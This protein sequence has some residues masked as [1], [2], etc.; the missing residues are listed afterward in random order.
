MKT[1][2]LKSRFL[3]LIVFFLS[4]VVISQ[5]TEVMIRAKSKDAKF[6]GTSLGGARIIVKDE[7]TGKILAQGMT[8]GSTG[9]TD[10][11]MNNPQLRGKRISDENTAGF[12]AKLDIKEPVFVTIEAYGPV[13]KKQ[14][15]VKTTTQ[16][17]IL[18]G[19]H[20]KGEGIILEIPGFVVDILSPQTHESIE[21]NTNIEITANVVMMC[22]CPVTE[23]GVWD[24]SKYEVKAL[25]SQDGTEAINTDLKVMG[26]P[27]TFQGSINLK[28]G[29]YEI[30]VYAFDPETGNTGVDKTNIIIQ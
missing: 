26:K 13:S 1:I 10:I 27:S 28:P 6:I 5:E 22:G 17:W 4:Q 11:I 2:Q 12:L 19:K 23:G 29:N 21:A 3:V 20:I 30:T 16:Q 24:A 15:A 25:I 8:R 9:D 14:A 7:S 18:P